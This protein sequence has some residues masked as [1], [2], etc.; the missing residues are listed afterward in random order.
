MSTEGRTALAI[1]VPAANEL[2]A[3]VAARFS[4]IVREGVPP[5]VT[6]QYP[7]VAA[8]M[9][10]E[11]TVNALSGLFAIQRPM[12][13]TFRECHRLNGFVY[14]RPDPAEWLERLTRRVR[15]YWPEVP[16]R[17]EGDVGPHLTVAMGASEQVARS[18]VEHTRAALP[19]STEMSDVWL[20]AYSETWTAQRS[21][22][23]R[24]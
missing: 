18:V 2:L 22:S 5:H 6:V 12:P 3:S 24:A 9:V 21:F 23:F 19:I 1:L 14:L 20:L 16:E 11:N 4:G 17:P 10:D 7:F 15:R 13:V 8:D